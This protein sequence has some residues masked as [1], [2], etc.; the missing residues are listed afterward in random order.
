RANRADEVAHHVRIAWRRL[1]L[2][3]D[4]LNQLCEAA[5]GIFSRIGSVRRLHFR[6][7]FD[8]RLQTDNLGS[9]PNTV[10]PALHDRNWMPVRF[11]EEARRFRR[12]LNVPTKPAN[13]GSAANAVA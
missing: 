13:I 9:A 7:H 1:I 4:S 12:S 3:E 2:V 8:N 11:K 5:A 10:V 6:Y